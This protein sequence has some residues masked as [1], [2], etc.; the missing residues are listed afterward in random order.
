M[1]DLEPIETY[2]DQ[3][4]E[5]KSS[6]GDAVI[7]TIVAFANSGGGKVLVGVDDMGYAVNGFKVGPETLQKWVNEIKLKTDPFIVPNIREINLDG[8]TVIELSI[9]EYPVKPVNF[10]GRYFR[11]IRNSNHQMTS[12][13]IAFMHLKTFNSSWDSHCTNNRTLDEISMDKVKVF[14]NAVK[15][16]RPGLSEEDP[17]KVLHKYELIKENDLANACHLLFAK[18]EVFGAAIDLG[19]FASPILIKDALTVQEDLFSEV[20]QVFQFV[21]KHLNVEYIISGKLHRDEKWQYPLDAIRE[22]IVNMV[23]HRDYT[24]YGTSSVKIFDDRIEFFNPGHLPNSIS[25]EQ[26]MTGNYIS[27]SRNLKIASIFKEV[28]LI[29]RYGSGISRICRLFKEHGLE[30]PVFENFQHGF[31]VIARLNPLPAVQIT[32]VNDLTEASGGINGGIMRDYEGL[33]EGLIEGLNQVLEIIRLQP[34]IQAKDIVMRLND[35]S[36]KTVER[37]IV[38]LIE[39]KLI[40]R[41]GSRKTGGYFVI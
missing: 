27:S 15:R 22:I 9:D 32:Q 14:M 18:N 30:A 25:I 12:S 8:V 35:R 1:Y 37:Q 2:E 11:R 7:E 10:K 41:K 38:R 19:R 17:A 16:I 13:E 34:G 28:G 40:Q 21:K 31:R 24:H 6:F 5:Y 20:E 33:N 39:N 4:T 26:L 3:H 29:E 36:I 23:V